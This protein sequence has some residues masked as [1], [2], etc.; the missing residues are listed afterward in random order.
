MF[1]E[2]WSYY[3]ESGK[4]GVHGPNIA[5]QFSVQQHLDARDM[6]YDSL[7]CCNIMTGILG[8]EHQLEREEFI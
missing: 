4:G 3:G 2:L 6:L 8:I 7:W 1:D 5:E